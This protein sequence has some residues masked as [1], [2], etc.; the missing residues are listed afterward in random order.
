MKNLIYKE[1]KLT[2]DPWTYIM[3][4]LCVL[5]LIPDWPY[6]I[7][8]M[9]IFIT[10]PVTFVVSKENKDTFF[11]VLL[12]VRK[13]DVVRARF[14]SVI[15][16]ELI[17]I[18]I[19]IPFVILNNSLHPFGSAWLLDPNPAFIGLVFIMY[20]I[21]NTIFL[22]LFYKT[23]YKLA[24][25]AVISIT[26]SIIFAATAEYTI[27]KIPILKSNFDTL[28]GSMI[29]EQILMLAAGILIFIV[30]T[31]FTFKKASYSFEKL[32]I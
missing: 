7:A 29:F 9:Y 30:A 26:A 18:I 11:T 14:I 1:L 4:L 31:I 23:A 13:K 19:S 24:V 3:P 16:M 17:Y 12:P 28:D 2:I 10:I 8:Y 21:F 5:L 6:F 22:S 25:P 20:A 27:Q 32:D 15:I